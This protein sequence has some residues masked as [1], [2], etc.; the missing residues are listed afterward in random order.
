MLELAPGLAFRLRG[1]IDRIDRL[2]T[3]GYE[4]VDYKTG[5]YVPAQYAGTFI[6]GRLLQHALYA[7]AATQLLRPR[8]PQAQ[9]TRSSYYLPTV[10]GQAQRVVYPPVGSER[11]AAVVRDLFDV[12]AAGAFVHAEDDGDCRYCDFGPACGRDAFVRGERK[13]ANGANVVLEPFRRLGAH[14]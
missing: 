8:D 11:L 2:D 7:V 12:L 4:V 14:E 1:R 9:V 6:G 10:R 5:W 13:I 3:G